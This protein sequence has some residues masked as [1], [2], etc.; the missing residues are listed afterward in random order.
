MDAGPVVRVPLHEIRRILES[1]DSQRAAQRAAQREQRCI[2]VPHDEILRVMRQLDRQHA[3]DRALGMGS[4]SSKRR[5]PHGEPTQR[6]RLRPMEEVVQHQ[7]QS[8]H[9]I[10]QHREARFRDKERAS[11]TRSWCN[12]D[13]LNLQVE[14]AKSFCEAF[15]DANTLQ[16]SHCVFCYK[17][18]APRKL[19]AIPWKILLTPFL[20]DAT[21]SLQQCRKCLPQQPGVE[22][23]VCFECRTS[24]EDGR[25][26]KTCSVNNM[27]IGC[28]HRYPGEL[29]ALSPIE[30]RLIA[31]HTP[32]GYITKFSV[33]NKTP[34]GIR[35]RR[36]VKGHIVVFPNKVEDFVATVLPH[37]LLQAI[38]NIHVSWSGSSEPGPADVAHLLQVRKSRVTAA[39]VWLQKNN[40][41]Y[42]HIKIDRAEMENWRYAD[43]TDVPS[44]IIARMRREEPSVGEKI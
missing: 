38:E 31:L 15:S 1:L 40:P 12:E 27:D 39:L 18:Q 26:P 41:L 2:R 14:A 5:K 35:Y 36:H 8:I 22:V 43:S 29:D 13:S 6:K 9:R 16:V 33:D 19:T 10:L 20:M 34:S 24:L 42:E 32:F 25:L 17:M 4:S 28:E 3:E 21:E 30:E 44:I 37:P 11:V 23:N 7:R